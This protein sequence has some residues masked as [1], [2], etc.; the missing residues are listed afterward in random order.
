LERPQLL[1]RDALDGEDEDGL[2]RGRRSLTEEIGQ[3]EIAAR[4]RREKHVSAAH[5]GRFRF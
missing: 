4:D 3:R 5:H 2:N 1:T